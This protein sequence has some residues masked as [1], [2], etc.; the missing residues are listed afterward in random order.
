MQYFCKDYFT[1]IFLNWKGFK[2]NFLIDAFLYINLIN[3][4]I[5]KKPGTVEQY[6]V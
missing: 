6:L 4:A 3:T 2:L 1:S 5:L